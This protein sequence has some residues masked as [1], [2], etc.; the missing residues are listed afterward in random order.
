MTTDYGFLPFRFERF[1]SSIIMTNEVGEYYFMPTAQFDDI[2]AK[3]EIVNREIL[4]DLKSK[5]FIYYDK[6]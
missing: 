4:R 3:R 5:D 1:D 6:K 2:L